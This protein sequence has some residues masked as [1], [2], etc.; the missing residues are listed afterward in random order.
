MKKNEKANEKGKGSRGG[1]N[2][3]TNG[4]DNPTRFSSS[5]DISSHSSPIG[6]PS[7]MAPVSGFEQVSTDTNSSSFWLSPDMI[8]DSSKVLCFVGMLN[9]RLN[10]LI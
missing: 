9:L 5:C 2:S 7:N 4:N 6:S 3:S 8:L 1:S 10:R